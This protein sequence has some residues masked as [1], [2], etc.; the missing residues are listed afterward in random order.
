[1]LHT[2]CVDGHIQWPEE[3]KKM[4]SL[5][6]PVAFVAVMIGLAGLTAVG[7]DHPVVDGVKLMELQAWVPLTRLADSGSSS[8]SWSWL[9]SL[10]TSPEHKGYVARSGNW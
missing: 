10:Q 3:R 5:L 2:R 4:R 8:L 7:T 9:A 1:M 6:L